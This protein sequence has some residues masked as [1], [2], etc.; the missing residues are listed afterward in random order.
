MSREF[1]LN[2]TRNIGIMAHIDAGKTTVTERILFYTGIIHKMGEVHHGNSIMDHM[3]QEKD[4]GITITSAAT[5]CF[6]K[7][8]IGP[9]QGKNNRINIIDT[10]GHVDFTMEVERSIR[11]LDGAIAV[12]DGG[13]GVEPQSETVWRQADKY[14]VPRL[15]FINKLDKAGADFQ[16][17]ID[18]IKDRLGVIPVP[19]AYP[20]GEGAEFI[21]LVDLIKMNAIIF[22]ESTEGLKF[23]ITSI[24]DNLLEKCNQLREDIIEHCASVDD[25]IMEKFIDDNS[26]DVTKDEI[27][28]A[29]R[30][31][32]LSFAFV[33]VLC[34]SA[35]KNKGIQMLL[36][37]IVNFLPSPTDIPAAKGM[38][39]NGDDSSREANDDAPFSALAFKITNDKHVGNLT[40]F[41]VYSGSVS[42]GQ[43]IY[44]ATSGRRERL[45]RILRMHSNKKED[46]DR[47]Y[48][49]NI[50]AA[51]GLKDT[52]T[53]NTLCDENNIILFE[54]IDSP[55][56]V[57]SISI[58][59]K[60][61]QDIEKISTALQRLSYEDPSLHIHTDEETGQTIM[62]GMGEL[63]LEVVVSRLQTEFGV[64]ASVGKPAVSYR[65]TIS[66]K[67]KCEHKHE[68]ATGG[69]GQYGHV[70]FD[71]EPN[72]KGAGFEFIN[73]IVGGKIPK[74]YIP[75]IEKGIKGAMAR[76]VLAH[77]E[78]IDCKVRLYDGSFHEVDS[79]GPSFEIA[80]SKA[81][82]EG[83][84]KAGIH[85]LEPIMNVEIIAPEEHIGDVIGDINSRRGNITNMSQRNNVQI[86]NA[87][88]PLSEM[89]GYVMTLRGFTHGRGNYTMIF[90]HYQKVP[91]NVQLKIISQES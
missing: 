20:I 82:Q 83:A 73:K 66:H 43:S 34:G 11:V 6:W 38:L 15:A 29:I 46:V 56:P 54:S 21:G 72:E 17:N 78:V 35:F 19:I 7:P 84:R 22:D 61:N 30:K 89:F 23:E 49:G 58:E 79:S 69:H 81:F 16:M 91:E 2:N 55:D 53:G 1:T 8:N 5:N 14:S 68:V 31:G 27:Y 10:P 90:S 85:L 65:E 52:K 24:P 60:T 87:T 37:A 32:T 47:C 33:P 25:A 57:I 41:R 36:D 26:S 59:P 51:V 67:V 75:S 64:E 9:Q 45:G 86:I 3:K 44:N 13:S 39:P 70:I 88:A 62:A 74:D 76:G 50:Y 12:F 48:S 18:S 80:A 28:K 71:L 4:R 63:H 40:F 77:Y 42:T